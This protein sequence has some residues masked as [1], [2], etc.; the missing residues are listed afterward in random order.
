MCGRFVL[1]TP[2]ADLTLLF[3]VEEEPEDAAPRYNVAPS[4]QIPVI[5][6]GKDG[7]R[8]LSMLRWGLIPMW[9]RQPPSPPPVNARSESADVKP[10]FR[11][12]F[13]RRRCI[14]PANGFYE[15]QENEPGKKGP[16]QPYLVQF[17]NGGPFAM[18]A[19]WERWRNP[20]GDEI[21]TVCVL[22]TLANEALTPVH[23][24]MPL[25][26]SPDVWDLWLDPKTDLVQVKQLLHPPGDESMIAIPVSTKVND[27]ANDDQSLLERAELVN[28]VQAETGTPR[29][30][31]KKSGGGQLDLF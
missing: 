23:H 15:W 2:S 8:H 1:H 3:Q 22:T 31:A 7:K 17:P 10:T 21:E 14:M 9:A 26:L 24:R 13:A 6:L 11:D 16:K 18:G 4:Q 20:N 5:R 12:A 25:I 28:N 19:V 30:S 29:K 27:V